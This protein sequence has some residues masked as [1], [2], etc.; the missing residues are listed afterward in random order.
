MDTVASLANKLWDEL[1]GKSTIHV[2]NISLAFSG[3]ENSETG[4]LGLAEFLKPPKPATAK[5]QVDDGQDRNVAL[6]Y[7]CPRCGQG[8]TAIPKEVD[9]DETEKRALLEQWRLEHDDFHFAQDL[10]KE[11]DNRLPAAG[12]SGPS[13][14]SR[15]R[16]KTGGIDKFF[17]RV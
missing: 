17:T 5:R 10:A 9:L 3:I 12:S 11:P 16:K 2:T 13:Q 14:P 1:V 8:M 4:Q 7:E 6:D 15:K